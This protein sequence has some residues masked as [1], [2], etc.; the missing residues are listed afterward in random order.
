VVLE[1]SIVGN[2]ELGGVVEEVEVRTEETTLTDVEFLTCVRESMYTTTF[3][4]P[5]AGQNSVTVT[6]P[7]SFAP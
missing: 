5:P 6:Y 2:D 4:A 7:F 1:L 3:D